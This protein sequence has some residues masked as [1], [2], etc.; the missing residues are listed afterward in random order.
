MSESAS[1]YVKF[2][3]GTPSAFEN[4]AQKKS[5]TLYFVLDEGD[6]T[7]KLY[8]GETLISG[9]VNEEGLVTY[10]NDLQDVDTTGVANN[11]LLGYHQATAS[12][13][14]MNPATVITVSNMT[15]ASSVLDGKSGLVPTPKAGE[16]KNFLRGDGVWSALTI[17]DIASLSSSLA[18]LV[19]LETF[20]TELAKKANT[21]DLTSAINELNL[22][23]SNK[24]D[25]DSVYT[26][27]ETDTAI[28][29]A[30]TK[31]SH[32]QRK[33][34][35]SVE[36]IY[37]YASNNA[38]ADKYIFMVASGLTLDDNKYY[39]YLVIYDEDG[40]FIVEKVGNWE[41]SLEDYVTS[42]EL[43]DALKNKVDKVYFTVPV[44]DEEGNP[45]YEEDGVT[46][47]TEQVEGALLSPTDQNKLDSLVIT[48]DGVEISGTVNAAN[49]QGLNEWITQNRDIVPGLYPT[50]IASDVEKALSD[51]EE[52]VIVTNTNTTDISTLNTRV[53]TIVNNLN[54]YVSLM[55]YNE[56]MASLE[57]NINILKDAVS[58]KTI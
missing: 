42:K 13:I 57:S 38:D 40:G 21:A 46:P 5:D 45:V 54:N 34:V 19:S 16:N 11:M 9:G 6:A 36:E 33:I 58:W 25:K 12:W 28:A 53:D 48:E 18:A 37:T 44:V 30:V 4:L 56:K 26:K 31:A 2:L 23:L 22:S 47:K 20:N 35:D 3:R 29:S 51:L 14:P 15:G 41:V 39:E 10:L 43:E 1:I 49:V 50:Q 32:L 8:L 55:E 17:D 24:P 7:G 27:N 52:L